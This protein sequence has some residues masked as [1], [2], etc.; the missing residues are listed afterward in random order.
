MYL[1]GQRTNK[2]Q[3]G[4]LCDIKTGSLLN[5]MIQS[6]GLLQEVYFKIKSTYSYDIFPCLDTNWVLEKETVSER[7]SHEQAVF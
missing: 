5:K 7:D 1:H 3:L 2:T 4:N 6:N